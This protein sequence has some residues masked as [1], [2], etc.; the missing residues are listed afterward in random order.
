MWLIEHLHGYHA[1]L[2]S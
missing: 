1:Q 2:P